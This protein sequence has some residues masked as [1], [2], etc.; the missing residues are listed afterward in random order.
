MGLIDGLLGNASKID[1]SKR[2]GSIYEV[3]AVL[4]AYVLK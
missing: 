4:A 2:E 3:Q 1:A